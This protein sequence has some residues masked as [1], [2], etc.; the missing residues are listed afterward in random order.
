MDDPRSIDLMVKLCSYV[1][2]TFWFLCFFNGLTN[3]SVKPLKMPERFDLG[4]IDDPPELQCSAPIELPR[5]KKK[6]KKKKKQPKRVAS[7]QATKKSCPAPNQALAND[8]K[9][10]LVGLGT[11]K[12]EAKRAATKFL[13]ENPQTKTV[14]EFLTKVF[15]SA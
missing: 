15:Q 3:K 2:G 5:V 7:A 4:Y 14:E 10:A 1:I 13:T 8:C 11:K 6:K 9:D 12:S